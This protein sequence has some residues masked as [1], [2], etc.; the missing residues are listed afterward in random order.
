MMRRWPC[1]VFVVALF[2]GLATEA[3]AISGNEYRA[4]LDIQRLFYLAG[5]LD[6]W[7]NVLEP[8]RALNVDVSVVDQMFQRV[9][10]CVAKGMTRGQVMAIVDKHMNDHPEAWHYTA[11]STAWVAM[12]EACKP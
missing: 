8:L 11:G 4:L 1:M 5:V 6:G 3:T 10:D 12:N 7:S 2:T 9:F